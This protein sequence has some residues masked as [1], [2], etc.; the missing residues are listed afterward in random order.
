MRELRHRVAVIARREGRPAARVWAAQ[1]GYSVKWSDAGL[2]VK[3]L[4]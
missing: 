1:R 4:V 3:P 2:T